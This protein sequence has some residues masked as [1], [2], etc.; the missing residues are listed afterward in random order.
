MGPSSDEIKTEGKTDSHL[1]NLIFVWTHAGVTFCLLP[2]LIFFFF[3]SQLFLLS[4][5]KTCLILRPFW[6]QKRDNI[7][8]KIMEIPHLL[9]CTPFPL[10]VTSESRR[11]L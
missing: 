5:Q 2:I 6:G 9:G 10:V 11:C 1:N 8:Y 3:L 4:G 7:W